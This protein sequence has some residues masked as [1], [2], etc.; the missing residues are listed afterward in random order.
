M[1]KQILKGITELIYATLSWRSRLSP[2]INIHSVLSR[3][4]SQSTYDSPGKKKNIQKQ[5]GTLHF[6]YIF[7]PQF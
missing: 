7:P 4:G 1:M 2:I 6:K 5:T 3:N